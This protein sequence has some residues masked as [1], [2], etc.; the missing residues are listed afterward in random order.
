[1]LKCTSFHT[2][3]CARD[4]DYPSDVTGNLS[5]TFS[6]NVGQHR[7]LIMKIHYDCCYGMLSLPHGQFHPKYS[8]S[9]NYRSSPRARS[10]VS[11]G[12]HL[13]YT[14][15]L[16]IGVQCATISHRD[17]IATLLFGCDWCRR[18]C[19]C[20]CSS[21]VEVT[22]TSESLGAWLLS[23]E[24]LYSSRICIRNPHTT[25]TKKM[26]HSNEIKKSVVSLFQHCCLPV[27][28]FNV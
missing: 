14:F 28:A 24:K 19:R 1:M 11:S 23:A 10:F 20:G 8:Q 12:C 6:R 3:V 4:C 27:T 15:S 7:I 9:K 5:T 22:Q 13:V 16:L 2:A 21:K 18:W 17:L 26:R 25:H